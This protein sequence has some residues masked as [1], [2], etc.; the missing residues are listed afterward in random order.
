ML[1]Q[2]ELDALADPMPQVHGLFD[3]GDGNF[4]GSRDYAL[5][6]IPCEVVC[7]PINRGGSCASPA[8]I[9]IK[10]N[11][12]CEHGEI[13]MAEAYKVVKTKMKVDGD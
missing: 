12:K 7:C 13:A 4:R 1:T 6:N 3:S 2:K 11:G 9:K 10:A 5:G 8:A